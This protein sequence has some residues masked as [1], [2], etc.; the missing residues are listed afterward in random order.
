[1]KFSCSNNRYHEPPQHLRSINFDSRKDYAR[2]LYYH[3]CLGLGLRLLDY[4][5]RSYSSLRSHTLPSLPPLPPSI[6]EPIFVV[7]FPKFEQLNMIYIR[8]FSSLSQ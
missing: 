1:M 4:V 5:H 8:S 2:L 6:S 3:L 7:T